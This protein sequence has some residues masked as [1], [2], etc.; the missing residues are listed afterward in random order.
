MSGKAE[1][2]DWIAALWA[3][4]KLTRLGDIQTLPRPSESQRKESVTSA[5]FLKSSQRI[6]LT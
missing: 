6:A 1:W 2:L 4:G 3:F 5:R